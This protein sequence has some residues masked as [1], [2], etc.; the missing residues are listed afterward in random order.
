MSGNV[1]ALVGIL[2]CL[3]PLLAQSLDKPPEPDPLLR[4]MED[5][6]HRSRNL[7]IISLD[8]P[9]YFEYRVADESNFSAAASLGALVT[10]GFSNVRYPWVSVRVGD[11]AFDN[12]NHIFSEAYSGSRYDPDRLALDG[13]YLGFRHAL[14]L[15][16]D[17]A[18]KTAEDAIARKR[19]SLKNMNLPEQLPDFSK[20]PAVTAVLP[21]RHQAVNET[22]WKDR[23][24]KL[25]A[26]FDAY[27]KV[28]SSGV[29]VQI[30]QATNYM[31]NSEGSVLRTPEN[32]SH[33]RIQGRGLASD[34]T[35]VR[36]ATV[37]QA[38]EAGGLPA[39][40]EMRRQAT[41]VANHITQLSEAPAGEA[42]DG[43]VLFEAAASAQLFGQMLGDNLKIARK[44]IVDAGRNA[45]YLPSD[46][47]NRVGSKI[48]PEWMDVVDDPTQ[49][50][51]RGQALL[52]HYLYDIE[53]VSP[54][55]LF[56]VDKG[57]L[58]SFLMTRTPVLKAF[59]TTNGRARMTGPYGA[60]SAGFG[61]LFVRA[62]QTVPLADLKKKLMDLCRD[63]NKPYGM[64]VRKLDFPSTA[65]VDEIRRLAQA[66]GNSRP[67]TLPLLVYRVYPDGREELVRGLRFRGLS[68]RSLKDILAA[69]DESYVFDFIDSNAIF[70]L[71]GAG[72]FTT[73]ASVIAPSV[74]F[75]EIELEPIHEETPN[76]PIVP[77]PPLSGAKA[78][79]AG[80]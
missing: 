62:T 31:V 8:V 35:Q 15:A 12:T 5:E 18:Y 32:L 74:L 7:R 64:L 19:S 4:A 66:G 67:V 13:D 48:L 76:A 44:P 16:T 38:F 70:A 30:A 10:S 56:L 45:P 1:R 6:L 71:V 78:T 54:A 51:W 72:S 27:P 34:G 17:R 3:V 69:S 77:P 41:E 58:K 46:L 79:S 20:A 49:T 28:L 21:I 11:Y 23:V 25:S 40:A 9:Y 26:I 39:E 57:T 22:L 42:Y 60:D 37:M 50:E 75:D 36:D 2:A 65:S 29:E 47:E 14:W 33:V 53:G 61:N 80:S 68:T 59:E 43:P 52:G 63:R 55:P 24:V 73:S